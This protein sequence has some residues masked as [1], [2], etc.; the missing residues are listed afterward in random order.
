MVVIWVAVHFCGLKQPI[1]CFPVQHEHYFLWVVSPNFECLHT[2]NASVLAMKD[3]V[4]EVNIVSP[5]IADHIECSYMTIKQSYI[6]TCVCTGD[7]A[8]ESSCPWG[9]RRECQTC[10][11]FYMGVRMELVSSA[12]AVYP[13]NHETISPDLV[14]IFHFILGHYFLCSVLGIESRELHMLGKHSTSEPPP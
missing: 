3:N 7:C 5:T 1:L 4:V 8:H 10:E 2:T 13:L 11:A 14:F 6:C 12:I 9:C